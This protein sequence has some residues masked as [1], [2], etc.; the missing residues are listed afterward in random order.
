MNTILQLHNSTVHRWCLWILLPNSTITGFIKIPK[1]FMNTQPNSTISG[2]IKI[3][4]MFMNTNLKLNIIRVH[5][6]TKGVYEYYTLILQYQG[7]YGYHRCLWILYPNSTIPGFI[8]IPKMFM[9]TIP[10]LNIIRVHKDTKDVDD[11][12]SQLKHIWVHK[13]Y[14]KY[15]FD[16]TAQYYSYLGSKVLLSKIFRRFD[17]TVLYFFNMWSFSAKRHSKTVVD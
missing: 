11:T 16:F 6:D 3:P 4:K 2:F 17:Y 12:F 9:N 7:S 15:H 5:K 13:K 14:Q 1:I 10:Q 8:W